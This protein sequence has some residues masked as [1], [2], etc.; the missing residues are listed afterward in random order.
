MVVWKGSY[1]CHR[2][3]EKMWLDNEGFDPSTSRMLSVRSTN[4]ASRPIFR[5]ESEPVGDVSGKIRIYISTY[6]FLIRKRHL[7]IIIM[8]TKKLFPIWLFTSILTLN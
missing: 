1:S 6:V 3:K 8:Q 5:Y 4:W 2:G 7:I